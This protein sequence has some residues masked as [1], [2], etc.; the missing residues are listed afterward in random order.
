[1]PDLPRYFLDAEHE[2]KAMET[3]IGTDSQE[4]KSMA[5]SSERYLAMGVTC[6]VDTQGEGDLIAERTHRY[7]TELKDESMEQ[8][9]EHQSILLYDCLLQT[10]QGMSRTAGCGDWR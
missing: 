2:C 1:M 10:C 7:R 4:R 6:G 5:G 3:L 9:S 8:G